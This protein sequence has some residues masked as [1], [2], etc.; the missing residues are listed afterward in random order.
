[1]LS[2]SEQP[3]QR[4]CSARNESVPALKRTPPMAASGATSRRSA[5]SVPRYW[6]NAVAPVAVSVH[7]EV[8]A[9]GAPGARSS[10]AA[11]TS[12]RAAAG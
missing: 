11:S 7:S 9:S 5:V 12:A 8:S 4:R 3:A 2:P 1:M 6:P 10:H